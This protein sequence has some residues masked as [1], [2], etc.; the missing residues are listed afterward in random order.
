MGFLWLGTVPLTSGTVATLFGVRYLATLYGAFFLS[1][2]VGAF[3]GVWLAGSVCDATGSYDPVWIIAIALG[4]TSALIHLPIDDRQR[5]AVP[6]P[7]E[8]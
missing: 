5:Y 8:S 6:R 7:Q 2:Q 1:H 4:L 3:L